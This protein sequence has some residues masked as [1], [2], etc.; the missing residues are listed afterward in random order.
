LLS[1]AEG[2]D[3]FL[4]TAVRWLS[5]DENKSTEVKVLTTNIMNLISHKAR[6]VW[7]AHHAAKGFES[8]DSMSLQNM[9]RGSNEYG[10][11][12]SNAYGLCKLDKES[13]LVHVSCLDGRDL[14]SHV[15]DFHIM[16]TR[17]ESKQ[18]TG[19]YV[20][21]PNA[22]SL[23]N[24]KPKKKRG[25]RAAS[26]DA[27][28]AI[29]IELAGQG[30]GRDKISEALVER[31]HKDATPARVRTVLEQHDEEKAEARE[32]VEAMQEQ[33]K[34]NVGYQKSNPEPQESGAV[35]F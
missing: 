2:A 33:G 19:F 13:A 31:G 30:Y 11:A 17:N 34:F 15:P 6:S 4:D 27:W 12:L 32:T 35:P 22:G 23:A 9:F 29:A 20:S 3:I 7:C 10:A 14:E 26:S 21:N 28:K 1:F 5:G 24:H 18:I 8:A 25:R 16:P